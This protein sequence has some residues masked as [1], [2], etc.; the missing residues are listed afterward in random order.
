MRPQPQINQ[1]GNA[2]SVGWEKALFSAVPTIE[3]P[4]RWLV[5]TPPDVFAPGRFA[6]PTP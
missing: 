1:R 2:E 3:R 5:G 6:H 4:R